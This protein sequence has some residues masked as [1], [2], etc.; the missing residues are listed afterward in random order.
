[1]FSVSDSTMSSVSNE[2]APR[3]DK[4]TRIRNSKLWK[5]CT[6]P[7][8]RG[9]PVQKTFREQVR[10]EQGSSKSKQQKEKREEKQ[11]GSKDRME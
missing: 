6:L 5:R 2:V 7:V 10:R 8:G 3:S 4:W 9:E 11:E 1:M